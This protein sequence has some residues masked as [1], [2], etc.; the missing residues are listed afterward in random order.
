MGT[1]FVDS[2]IERVTL[3]LSPRLSVD[4]KTAAKLTGI[5]ESTLRRHA[6]NGVLATK[7]IAGRRVVPISELER[8]V[9]P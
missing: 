2:L 5:G 8:L 7:R 9:R 4:F 1:T 6:A 3:P